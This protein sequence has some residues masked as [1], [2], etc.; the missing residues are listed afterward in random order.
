MPNNRIAGVLQNKC[1]FASLDRQG[2][3]GI[4]VVQVNGRAGSELW[5]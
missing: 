5:R 2:F 1:R 4:S 3:D